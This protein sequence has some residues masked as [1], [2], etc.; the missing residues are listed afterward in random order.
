MSK[1]K[2]ENRAGE[3]K[4]KTEADGETEREEAE[5]M[6]SR[7]ERLLLQRLRTSRDYSQ[8]LSLS[9]DYGRFRLNYKTK[10][11][12]KKKESIKQLSGFNSHV[13]YKVTNR[14]REI[15]T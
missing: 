8:D 1:Q 5:W 10:Q 9:T 15:P 6:M 2:A 7:D 4:G 13:F 14:E 3:T 12:K 11:Q